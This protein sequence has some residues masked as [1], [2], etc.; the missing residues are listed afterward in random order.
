[1]KTFRKVLATIL[2]VVMIF[3]SVPLAG[4]VGLDWTEP[5]IFS[6]KAEAATESGI[7][8][9]GLTWIYD[10]DTCELTISGSGEMY[11]Y[12]NSGAPWYGYR[13]AIKKLIINNGVTSI[14]DSAFSDCSNL[15]SVYIADTVKYIDGFGF[16]YCSS[17]KNITIPD[18]VKSI[19]FHVFQGCKS[20]ESI[21]IGKGLTNIDF[22]VFSGCN[23]L[24]D[25]YYTGDVT[26][27][28]KIDFD[29]YDS[30]PMCFAK[31]LYFGNN[32]ITELIIPEGTKNIN[33]Y[34][35]YGCSGITSVIIPDSVK[36]IGDSAFAKC[37]SLKSIVITENVETI[38]SSAFYDCLALESLVFSGNIK[39]IGATAFYGC[40]NLDSVTIPDSVERIGDGA[41]SG[42]VQI[43]CY[44]NS[45]A[46]V[47]AEN[48]NL[49]YWLLDDEQSRMISGNIGSK[50]S[51]LI[52]KKERTLT[53]D[54]NGPMVSFVADAAPWMKYEQYI[55][56]ATINGDSTNIGARAFY[57][58]DNLK[59]VNIS[60]GVTSIDDNAFYMCSKLKSVTIPDSVITIGN[61]AFG[62]CSNLTNAVIGNNVTSIGSSAFNEC[63][64]LTNAAIGDSVA[65]IGSSA[66]YGCSSL[67]SIT[68]PDST[69]TIS[70]SAFY[71]C[72]SLASAAIGNNV[73]SIGSSAFYGCSSLTSITI[74]D[75]T[76][77]IG[78]SAF[79]SCSSLKTI[80]I[81]SGVNKLSDSAFKSCSC[82]ESISV[83]DNVK[84]IGNQTF[85][86]CS[87][88]AAAVIGNG[89]ESIGGSAF[90]SCP[91]LSAVYI[92]NKNCS[93]NESS[94]SIYSTIYGYTGS[95]AETFANRYGYDFVSIDNAS[96]VR[97]TYTNSCDADCNICGAKRSASHRYGEW[98]VTKNPT[99]LATGTKTKTCSVCSNL[100]KDI[101]AKLSH[102]YGEWVV[103]QNA[104]CTTTGR[105]ERICSVSGCVEYETIDALL[106]SDLNDDFICD[107]C[108]N[109]LEDLYPTEG[110]CGK[111]LTWSL[112]DEGVLL[113]EGTGAMYNFSE[114]TNYISVDP[115]TK[116]Q[117]S[118]SEDEY[119]DVYRWNLH[120]DKIKK[121]VIGEGVTSICDVV[122][123]GCFQINT[124]VLNAVNCDVNNAFKNCSNIKII[125]I[126]NKVESIPAKAFSGCSNLEKVYIPDIV[127]N[128]DPLAFEGCGKATIVCK[129]GSYAHLY[130][131][132]NGI[133]Y[134]LDNNNGTAFEIKN[135]VLIGY[136]GTASDVVLPADTASI[137]IDAF[138]GNKTVEHIEIP[139]SVTKIY[140]GAFADCPNLECVVIPFTVT[141]IGDSAFSGTN[142]KIY[143]YYNSYAYNY[144]VEN[145]ISYEL[146]TVMLSIYNASIAEGE[147]LAV[148]AVPNITLSSGVPYVWKSENPAVA[149]VDANGNI[150]GNANGNTT[151][152]VYTP[153]GILLAECAVE[154]GGNNTD[155]PDTPDTPDEP[156][157]DAS[158]I[159][160]PT[161]TT[162]RYGDSI[163][164]HVDPSKIP[165]GGYA[166]WTASNSNF[167][168]SVSDDGATCT[169]T[170]D[171]KGDTTF[172]A[173]IYD[174]NGNEILKDEQTM[175]SKAGLFD[176]II[177]FFKKLFGATKVIPQAFKGIF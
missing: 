28:L 69:I 112:D 118:S 101:L 51:W 131:V 105:R 123:F 2:C 5:N 43:V 156:V 126:G 75:S 90:A 97:H 35:F 18:S 94:I 175:T 146:I 14:G 40:S 20:L 106:H 135:S 59:S 139:Y 82:L 134:I 4:F 47:F 168:Y 176:K 140:N 91:N 87:N 62:K 149:S 67:T 144:A 117:V 177:A 154:V 114:D 125:S 95:T 104:T 103:T 42:Y 1:M 151:V 93:I 145:G 85:A 3:G 121:V 157:V 92:Y 36:T 16:Y 172:T 25:V 174:A 153:E 162:I 142:A 52:D 29:K 158:V 10:R 55:V 102:N 80:E 34:A 164:L 71:G 73:T 122:F 152:G 159:K 79:N 130:A 113:I 15:E 160:S 33:N 165:D 115:T 88:L 83:P 120:F 84:S 37:S 74:P 61:A 39:N 132:Q 147:T 108:G 65:N 155:E 13:K 54:C 8:G 12:R 86:G 133:K 68:I 173:T 66:F 148:Q 72:T 58:C 143:C 45:V 11:G 22:N 50:L 141:E 138:K 76:I 31:N 109:S 27:W 57:C 41:F 111:N 21:T 19:G 30:N 48:A 99:C 46:H 6:T 98:V 26:D 60:N 7:C 171:K 89:V 70:D 161:V 96:C 169:I 119:I 124:I 116:E 53:I 166:E 77:T 49:V 24:N 150:E 32:L 56:S 64:S 136:N 44:K 100:K 129:N 81:G 170:P 127:I 9:G 23:N 17:L 167:S 107:S 110:I 128:M 63:N 38:G 137:G 78:Y 163:L